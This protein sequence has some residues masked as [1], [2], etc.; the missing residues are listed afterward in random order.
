MRWT[1]EQLF[2]TGFRYSNPAGASPGWLLYEPTTL[3]THGGK[4]RTTGGLS[5]S[6]WDQ[7]GELWPLD[8]IFHL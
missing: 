5:V 4:D 7:S 2:P 1:P 3:Q 6:S 8:H